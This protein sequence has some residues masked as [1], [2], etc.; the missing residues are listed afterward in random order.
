[1]KMSKYDHLVFYWQSISGIMLFV[2]YVTDIVIIGSDYVGISSLKSFL[3][4]RFH[5]KDFG[6][7]KYFLRVEVNRSKKENFLSQ[8]KYILN[9]LADIGML[10]AKLCSIPMVPNVHLMKDD[11]IFLIT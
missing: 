3:H 7:L 10:P 2:A 9:V 4:T 1:M 5:T 11:R 8:R 6:S